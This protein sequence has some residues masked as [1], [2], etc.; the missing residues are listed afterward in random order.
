MYLNLTPPSLISLGQAKSVIGL[1][2]KKAS[3]K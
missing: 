3:S 2:K 1:V